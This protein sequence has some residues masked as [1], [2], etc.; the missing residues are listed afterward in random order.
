MSGA[1]RVLLPVG[2]DMSKEKSRAQGPAKSNREVKMMS[3]VA[4][5]ASIDEIGGVF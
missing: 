4:S 1:Y 2:F 5:P 3:A